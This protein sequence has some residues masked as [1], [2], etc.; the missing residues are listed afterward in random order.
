MDHVSS[1]RFSPTIETFQKSWRSSFYMFPR[2]MAGIL[3]TLLNVSRHKTNYGKYHPKA[4]ISSQV[5]GVGN[6][7]SLFS[8]STS[9]KCQKNYIM[10][11]AY[12][13]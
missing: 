4:E 1:S 13:L 6:S 8:L 5:N 11:K 9:I 12:L 7:L 2:I 10:F 3:G